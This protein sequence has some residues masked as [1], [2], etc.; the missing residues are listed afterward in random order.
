M[1]SPSAIVNEL[2]AALRLG[3][4]QRRLELLQRVTDLFVSNAASFKSEHLDLFDQVL[5]RLADELEDRAI[6]ELSR[7]LAPVENA[8][9]N[10]VRRL[11][12]H[13]D[14]EVAGPVLAA[15]ERLSDDDLIEVSSRKSQA[16]LNRIASRPQLR[17]SV[18]DVLVERG[19][20]AVANTLAANY[21]A[22]LSITGMW[23]LAT[24]A[25]ADDELAR[26]LVSRRDV[27]PYIFRQILTRAA[28]HARQKLVASAQPQVRR[29]L[30]KILG[31]ISAQVRQESISHDYAAAQRLVRSLGQDSEHI[32]A[33]LIHF[34][35]QRSIPELIVALS[36]LSAVPID[37]AELLVYD[38]H[39]M[40]ILVL[41]RALSLDWT[42]ALAIMV[43]RAGASP[44]G[45]SEL[46]EARSIFEA[47]SV[48]GAQ[49][50]IRFWQT[51]KG[52]S[53]GPRKSNAA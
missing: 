12:N 6:A 38:P 28:S 23:H 19:N 5:G 9:A 4:T 7:R 36:I 21:G 52:R 51:Q 1:N 33:Q 31:E 20:E 10:I 15:S 26:R 24:R 29:D 37:Q 44:P 14:I 40:G 50:A 17:E 22:R 11:A 39:P 27:P 25:E 46:A 32:K 47:L 45:D 34:A 49:R 41:C 3:S 13:D 53:A 48:S 8:P 43:S 2:E 30:E 35:N 42:F 16:H 18:T